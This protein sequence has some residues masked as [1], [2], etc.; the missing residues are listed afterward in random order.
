MYSTVQHGCCPAPGLKIADVL[1]L[2]DRISDTRPQGRT[3]V[4]GER[5][6][7]LTFK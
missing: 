3:D 4:L 2:I 6:H 1:S 5:V 7:M